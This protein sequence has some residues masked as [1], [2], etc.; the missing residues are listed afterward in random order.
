MQKCMQ[1]SY[2]V[3]NAVLGLWVRL[4][5]PAMRGLKTEAVDLPLKENVECRAVYFDIWYL[6]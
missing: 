5:S 3:T 2:N 4:V 6:F 1:N